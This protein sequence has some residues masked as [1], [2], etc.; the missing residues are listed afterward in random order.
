MQVT[1]LHCNNE[2]HCKLPPPPSGKG[3]GIQCKPTPTP[4]GREADIRR[5]CLGGNMKK[6]NKEKKWK[7]KKKDATGKEVGKYLNHSRKEF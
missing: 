1:N 4:L 7:M 6:V 5:C 3:G 2:V